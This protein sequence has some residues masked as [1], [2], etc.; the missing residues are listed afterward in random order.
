M[1]SAVPVL[2][3][4]PA[5]TGFG[6]GLG[7]ILA[8]G[9]QNA[10]VLRQGVRREHVGL[11]VLICALSDILLIAT[12]TGAIGW[13][14][15]MAPWVLQVLRWGGVLYLVGF[16]ASSIRSALRPG[17]LEQSEARPASSV[18]LTTLALTWL[19]PHVYLDT[20]VMLGTVTNSYGSQRWMAAA[21]AMA[22][23]VVWFAGLGFGAHAL[24]KPLASPRTWR[25][26]DLLV[27]AV[28]LVVAARLA[29]GG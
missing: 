25:V 1:T 21:G 20:V 3:Y 18:A 27:A 8:I 12:G 9:A 24:S 28:M 17:S 22:A 6:T 2:S 26:I 23:S 11:V 5:L 7:L 15:S 4:T 13:V 10:W 19:N 16:A 29:L 14:S